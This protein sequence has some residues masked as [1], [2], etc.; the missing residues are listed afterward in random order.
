MRV[1]AFW[2]LVL[3]LPGCMTAPERTS[4]ITGSVTGNAA[5]LTNWSARG[6]LGINSPAQSGS[7][8]FDWQ[9]QPGLSQVNLRGPAG[10]G[11]LILTLRGQ[12][13][14]VAA[15]DGSTYSADA[16]RAELEQRLGVVLPLESLSRWLRGLPDDRSGYQWLDADQATLVQAGWQIHYDAWAQQGAVRLPVRLSLSKDEVRV[17]VKIQEWRLDG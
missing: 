6:R 15:S 13:W 17:T 3:V 11:G 7:G 4:P 10:M 8:A 14:E 16:A 1:I 12:Q 2:L 5:A 9:Q